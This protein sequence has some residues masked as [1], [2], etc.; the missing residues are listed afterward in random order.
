MSPVEVQ[1]QDRR[2]NEYHDEDDNR[3]KEQLVFSLPLAGFS[4]AISPQ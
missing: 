1:L 2:P 4:K 3:A